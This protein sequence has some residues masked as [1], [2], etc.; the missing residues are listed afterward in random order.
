VEA[1][2]PDRPALRQVA[3]HAAL[4]GTAGR[5]PLVLRT[6]DPSG[7]VGTA[8]SQGAARSRCEADARRLVERFGAIP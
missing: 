5:D 8:C 6:A 7:E 2:W 1:A 3:R 4:A